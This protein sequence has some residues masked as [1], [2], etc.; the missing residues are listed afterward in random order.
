MAEYYTVLTRKGQMTVPADIRREL[1]LVEGDRLV[2]TSDCGTVTIRRADNVAERTA[3]MLKKYARNHPFIEP[4]DDGEAWIEAAIERD[5]E[6]ME[7]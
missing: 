1:G 7:S 3:G 2:V 4:G 5:L 6:S